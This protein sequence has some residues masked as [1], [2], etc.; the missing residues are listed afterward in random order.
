MKAEGCL[1]FLAK[2]GRQILVRAAA[3]GATEQTPTLVKISGIPLNDADAHTARN[4][5]G[6]GLQ[7]IK[8]VF[9]NGEWCMTPSSTAAYLI[10]KGTKNILIN[11]N[12][13]YT[14]SKMSDTAPGDNDI[15]LFTRSGVHLAGTRQ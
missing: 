6:S 7:N 1:V 3:R 11:T 12:G 5:S 14:A 10:P 13:H 15:E 9:T 8:D 4:L 2:E